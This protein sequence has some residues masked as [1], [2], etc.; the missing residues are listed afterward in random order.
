[1]RRHIRK[2]NRAGVKRSEISVCSEG[3]PK[4]SPL[5]G[6]PPRRGF[7]DPARRPWRCLRRLLRSGLK[8]VLEKPRHIPR[9]RH[10]LKRDDSVFPAQPNAPRAPVG[11]ADFIRPESRSRAADRFSVVPGNQVGAV[12]K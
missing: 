8:A 2:L 1:M 4:W 6:P 7:M 11:F 12:V 5:P 3:L 9:Y 10:D